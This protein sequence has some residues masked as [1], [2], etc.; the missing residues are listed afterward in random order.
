MGLVSCVSLIMVLV[1]NFR[2]SLN[3]V[4]RPSGEG[5]HDCGLSLSQTREGFRLNL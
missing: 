1:H 4:L 2:A 5:D 3:Q